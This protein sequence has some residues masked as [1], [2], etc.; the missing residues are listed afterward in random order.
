MQ[1]YRGMDIGT[2]KPTPAERADVTYHLIDVIDPA[3]VYTVGSYQRTATAALA[4]IEARGHRALLVGGTGLYLQ[5]LIDGFQLPGRY[6]QVRAALE[7]QVGESGTAALYRELEELDPLAAGR[8]EPA[9]ARRIVRALEVCRGTG[10]PFSSFGPGLDAYPVVD[11]DLV[12]LSWPRPELDR[13]IVARY[14]AQFEAGFVAEVEGLAA[15]PGGLGP[16]ARQALGYREILAHLD[17]A[18]SLDEAVDLAIRRTRR[19]ARRQERWFRRD[20]RL[21]W[22]PVQDNAMVL[23]PSLLEDWAPCT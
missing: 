17:G 23:L 16:T 22:Q 3:D 6:P 13:R 9:N 12:A 5:A 2:A 21:R 14:G 19:F 18:L 4:E 15:R 10:R 7:A 20:P 11:V 8:I 1:V